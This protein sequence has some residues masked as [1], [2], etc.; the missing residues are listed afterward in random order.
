[1]R[2]TLSM[3]PPMDHCGPVGRSFEPFPSSALEGSIIDRFDAIAQ[4]FSE[5][6][7]LSD[8]THRLTYGELAG[9]VYRIAAAVSDSAADRSAPVAIVLSRDVLFPTAMLGALASGR[10]FVPLDAGDPPERIRH[11]AAQSGAAAVISAGEL[12]SQSR[13]LFSNDFAG[14]GRHDLLS[15]SPPHDSM[16]QRP[17]AEGW[18]YQETRAT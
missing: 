4:R 6:V 13:S 18:S 1:V 9:L 16:K 17:L 15:V 3:R 5:R 12:A 11:V 10:G 14:S 7:A 8:C 2:S